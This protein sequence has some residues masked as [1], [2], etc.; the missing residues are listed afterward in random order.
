[1]SLKFSVNF[2]L[3]NYVHIVVNLKYVN[4]FGYTL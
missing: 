4:M 3:A 1:M 2:I